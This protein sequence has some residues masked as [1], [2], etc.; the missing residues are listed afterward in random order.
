MNITTLETDIKNQM[1]NRQAIQT[2]NR[3]LQTKIRTFER[4][5]PPIE[6]KIKELQDLAMALDEKDPTLTKYEK[7]LKK[8]KTELETSKTQIKENEKQSRLIDKYVT[9]NREMINYLKFNDLEKKLNKNIMAGLE[10][11]LSEKQV[12]ETKK[13]KKEYDNIK[14]QGLRCFNIISNAVLDNRNYLEHLK[15]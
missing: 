1:K 7:R 10:T 13:I 5:I 11:P 8:I 6:E 3:E 9:R 15:D 4:S 2:Q 14:V 12:K